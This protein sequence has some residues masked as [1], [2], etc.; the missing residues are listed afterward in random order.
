MPDHRR[1][2]GQ[3]SQ[4]PTGPRDVLYESPP[5]QRRK[6]VI[7]MNALGLPPDL[8]ADPCLLAAAREAICMEVWVPVRV[9]TYIY[10]TS[11]R[12]VDVRLGWDLG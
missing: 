5:R 10:N 4:S 7:R 6:V 11:G 8:A 3:P 12:M 2:S 1:G 9:N